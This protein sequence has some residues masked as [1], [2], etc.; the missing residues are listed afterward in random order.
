LELVIRAIFKDAND[1]THRSV[2]GCI[3]TAANVFPA[4]KA[5]ELARLGKLFRELEVVKTV[6]AGK[7][8]ELVK[9]LQA[10][11]IAEQYTAARLKQLPGF[12]A[13]TFRQSPIKEIDWVDEMGR[14]YD[15]IGGPPAAARLNPSNPRVFLA[16][17]DRHVNKADFT[18]MDYTGFT[19]EQVDVV[20][21]YINT[22]PA[23]SQSKI[24]E[25][26]F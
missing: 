8:I 9:G 15:A 21:G 5:G 18:V 6:E 20:T 1:C 25:V 19:Q 14:T 17:I 2:S 10:P 13:R 16:A 23:Y 26:G 24:I 11:R 22:L 3:W 4:G 12:R 7:A